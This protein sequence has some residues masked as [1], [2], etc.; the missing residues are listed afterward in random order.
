MPEEADHFGV[1]GW[2]DEG[3]VAVSE[4]AVDLQVEAG[5]GGGVPVFSEGLHS[6]CRQ[7][8]VE[9][10]GTDLRSGHLKSDKEENHATCSCLSSHNTIIPN[11]Q[12]RTSVSFGLLS[13]QWRWIIAQFCSVVFSIQLRLP[14]SP[15]SQK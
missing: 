12:G 6:I 7:V 15:P 1:R 4:G 3:H 8:K 13:L 10:M 5:F 2:A 14:I 11:I 9:V